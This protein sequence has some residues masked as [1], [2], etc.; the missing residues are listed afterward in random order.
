MVRWERDM[1][2]N[3]CEEKDFEFNDSG[4]HRSKSRGRGWVLDNQEKIQDEKLMLIFIPHVIMSSVKERKTV[5]D[6]YMLHG[7]RIIA[8]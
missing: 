5:T 4:E 8:L 7:K 2:G 3:L 6:G 1:E